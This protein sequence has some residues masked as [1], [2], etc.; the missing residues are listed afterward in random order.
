MGDTNR[1]QLQTTSARALNEEVA[2]ALALAKILTW[3]RPRSDSSLRASRTSAP[4]PPA[5]ADSLHH[6]ANWSV[7]AIAAEKL[8]LLYTCG[9][10]VVRVTLFEAET[11][12]AAWGLI[13]AHP[14]G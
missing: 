9:T 11:G 4:A 5:L 1:L 8:A 2:A 6:L 10:R 12:P 3:D 13:K 14:F 7:T